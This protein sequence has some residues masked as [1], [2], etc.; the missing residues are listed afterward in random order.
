MLVG[1]FATSALMKSFLRKRLRRRARGGSRRTARRGYRRARRRSNTRRGR[2]SSCKAKYG[3]D[4]SL[5]YS[6]SCINRLL[7][8]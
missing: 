1:F 6:T 5:N 8:L 3:N 2:D 7:N 4:N